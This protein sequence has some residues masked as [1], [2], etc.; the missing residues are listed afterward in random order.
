L[1]PTGKQAIRVNGSIA[2]RVPC[3]FDGMGA[4]TF[5]KHVKIL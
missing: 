5:P 4:L 2:S 3:T 1:R